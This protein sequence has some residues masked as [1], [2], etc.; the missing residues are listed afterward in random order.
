MSATQAAQ[1]PFTG[2]HMALIMV[3]F[4]LVVIGVNVFMAVLANRSWT[5]LVVQNSYVASQHFNAETAKRE[6]ILARGYQ[7]DIAYNGKQL[8][9]TALDKAGQ[10]LPVAS[11]TLQLNRS[12]AVAIHGP[13]ALTCRVGKC[14]VD[15]ALA[16]GIWRGDLQV[17][18]N[19]GESWQQAVEI[20]VKR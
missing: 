5:G 16:P 14:A 18:L 6:A 4:F 10:P 9:L 8:A 11:A 2:R 15:A 12:D 7:L 13:L 19:G 3:S 1:R 20:L 17:S